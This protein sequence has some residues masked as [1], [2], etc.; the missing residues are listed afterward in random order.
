[1]KLLWGRLWL[2]S[3][4][5]ASSAL[6]CGDLGQVRVEPGVLAADAC[7]CRSGEGPEG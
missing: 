2:R 4:V 7:R 6:V 3:H 1:M 5:L